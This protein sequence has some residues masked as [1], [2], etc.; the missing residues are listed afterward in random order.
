MTIIE[1]TS[2]GLFSYNLHYRI[3]NQGKFISLYSV[4]LRKSK[5][6]SV[7]TLYHK[8]IFFFVIFRS[9]LVFC[10]LKFLEIANRQT[11]GGS[12][13]LQIFYFIRQSAAQGVA[14]RFQDCRLYKSVNL[15]G[16][17]TVL[18]IFRSVII[19]YLF[20]ILGFIGLK[21]V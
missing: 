4:P 16:V 5:G 1:I 12:L 17:Q 14:S 8:G 11:K 19:V 10:M 6:L 7:V 20:F 2:L 18:T 21:I 9:Q 3:S 13:T 15:R